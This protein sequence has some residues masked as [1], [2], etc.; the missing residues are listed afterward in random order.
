MKSPSFCSILHGNNCAFTVES[1]F[2]FIQEFRKS[3][4]FN[5]PRL[6]QYLTLVY[7][8][9]QTCQESWNT[10]GC[11][12]VDGDLNRTQTQG[13][14][15]LVT[16]EFYRL[17]IL[18]E[19]LKPSGRPKYDLDD[20]GHTNETLALYVILMYVFAF[21]ALA[22]SH[23]VNGKLAWM[24]AVLPSLCLATLLFRYSCFILCIRCKTINIR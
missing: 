17:E 22:F 19:E 8:L 24:T 21:L 9:P 20:L 18:K 14:S 13:K 6:W 2:G 7:I 4:S 1:G 12:K 11:T 16:E 5:I 10:R 23:R 3:H 15:I